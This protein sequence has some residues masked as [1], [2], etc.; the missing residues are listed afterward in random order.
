LLAIHLLGLLADRRTEAWPRD[1]RD[2][3]DLVCSLG[4]ERLCYQEPSRQ[5]QGFRFEEYPTQQW[6]SK[7]SKA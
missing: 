4:T 5:P 2:R 6:R 7:L 1:R 3:F